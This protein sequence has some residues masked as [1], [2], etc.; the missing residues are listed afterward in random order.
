[1]GPANT[2]LQFRWTLGLLSANER[3]SEEPF[4]ESKLSGTSSQQQQ[5]L[6]MQI[7]LQVYVAPQRGLNVAWT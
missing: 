2:Q 3:R 1:M 5:E 4:D 6:C 7:D